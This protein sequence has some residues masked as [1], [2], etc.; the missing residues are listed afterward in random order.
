MGPLIENINTLDEARDDVAWLKVYYDD[1]SYVF[2]DESPVWDFNGLISNFGGLIGFWMG[3]SVLS[4]IEVFEIIFY[5]FYY[6]I[7]NN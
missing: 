1:I 4:F 3:C 7:K 5:F 6:S 2:I